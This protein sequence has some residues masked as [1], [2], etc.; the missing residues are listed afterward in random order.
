MVDPGVAFS[1][2]GW[3]WLKPFPT[4]MVYV[5]AAAAAAADDAEDAEDWTVESPVAS[6][7]DTEA[8]GDDHTDDVVTSIEESGIEVE[9]AVVDEAYVPTETYVH[10]DVV[11]AGPATSGG[12]TSTEAVDPSS[13][14]AEIAVD[15]VKV[16]EKT[17][18]G[19]DDDDDAEAVL[20]STKANMTEM[21]RIS[22]R[23][24]MAMSNMVTRCT[25]V[26]P[27]HAQACLC[28]MYSR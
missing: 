21:S 7:T 5:A 17:N 9:E 23:G 15:V 11:V 4:V 19:S 16:D 27:F 24:C 6:A 2:C 22:D 14:V 1:D 20:A 28:R 8:N 12:P 10:T 3:N 26:L 13:V 25:E 18:S